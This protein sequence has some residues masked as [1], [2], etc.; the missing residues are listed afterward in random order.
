MRGV[1]GEFQLE[2]ASETII[3]KSVFYEIT[4]KGKKTGVIQFEYRE[5]CG[6]TSSEWMMLFLVV[7]GLL[8]FIRYD[9]FVGIFFS[10]FFSWIKHLD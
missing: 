7:L 6:D 2:A 8:H 5:E 9:I 4:N 1:E 3:K 10:F